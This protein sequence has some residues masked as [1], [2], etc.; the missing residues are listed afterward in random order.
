MIWTLII[1]GVAG[2]LTGQFNK[3]EGYGIIINIILGILGGWLGSL[4]LGILGFNAG[5]GIIPR[6]ITATVGA[7][8]LV[9]VYK[10]YIK[11]SDNT[12]ITNAE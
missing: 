4:L 1:G 11:E 9:W 12:D 3:G 5:G 2:W 7:F 6:L 8:I 10:K